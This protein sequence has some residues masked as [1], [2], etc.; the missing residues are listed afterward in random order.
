[1]ARK[2]LYLIDG[3]AQIYRAYYAPF[4]PLTSPSGEPTRATF[5]FCQMLLNLLRGRRPDY[6]A[7]VMDVSDETVFRVE[8]DP[9]Y[10]AHREPPPEDMSPQI[11]RIVQIIEALGIP[12]LRMQGFEADDIMATLCRRHAGRDADVFLVSKDK[13]LEQLLGDGVRM[14][15]PGKD[16]VIDAAAMQA[17]KGY[18]PAK[19][20]DAQMLIGDSVDNVRGLTG[21]GP[22]KAAELL[23]KYGDVAGIIAH[24]DELSPKLRENVQ[25]FARRAE[26]VRLLVTLKDD[27]PIE[28]ALDKADVARLRGEAALPLF[29]ELGFHRLTEQLKAQFGGAVAAAD[30]PARADGKPAAVEAASGNKADRTERPARVAAAVSEGVDDEAAGTLFARELT[31]A[32]SEADERVTSGAYQ[33][34]DSEAALRE[35]SKQLHGMRGF[36]FDTETTSLTPADAELCGI[37]ISW[38]AG[39]ATYVAVRGV[40][41]TVDEAIVRDVLGPIFADERIAKCGQN[42]KYD[43]GVL[44]T[45]GIEVRGV[46]FDTMIASFVLDSS[47]RSHGIDALAL[48]LLGIRKI[49]TSE[50]IGRGK[51]Q[52]RFDQLDTRRVCAYACED[53]DVAWRLKELFEPQIA[54]RGMEKLFYELEMPLVEVLAT[55]EHH[56][57][58]L[59][60]DLLARISNEMAQRLEQLTEQIHAAAGCAF[61][62]DSTKQLAEVLFDRLN[63]PV[64]KRTKTGRSTDAAVLG[65]LASLTTHP[66]PKLVLEYRELTKLKGTYVDTLPEM[67]SPRTGRVHCS[68]H[69]TG[70]VTGRLSSS[71]PNLQNIP[72]RTEAGAQIRRAFVPRARRAEDEAAERASA[73]R[74]RGAAA[75]KRDAADAEWAIMSADY[76]QIELRVLAHFCGDENLCRA[77]REDRDIH[78]FVASQIFSVP[79]EKVGKEQRGRAKT[80]NFGIIYGQTA[81]GLARQTGMSQGEARQFIEA[82]FRQYP[83]IQ[84][85]LD[86]CIEQARK[87]GFVETMLGRRRRIDDIH[88]RNQGARQAAERLA[89]NTVVQGTAAD[90]IKRA[91]INIHRRIRDE[92]RPLRM[93]IQVH[94]E[95][96][97]ELPKPALAEEARMVREEMSGAIPLS[98]PVKV[99]VAA[100]KNW[101]DGEEIA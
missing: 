28:F 10:K 5:V 51:D 93:L 29:V 65:D 1:M 46:R 96:V 80:V 33:L 91:M 75:A 57:V 73:P 76:S 79:I 14:Y 92:G 52:L 101:L 13:D 54:S 56:G 87:H 21:V 18:P 100:G 66:V 36:A 74:A 64:Q 81:F 50:L 53:A 42:L 78:A 22:K 94:D 89:V 47:R 40:G 2:T 61:N 55:M 63:L 25:E 3:H 16:E 68:F 71:D 77:F 41:R 82:Y 98:V 99:D 48:D 7:M 11:E 72:I 44:M 90:I 9:E 43:I 6:L 26:Q 86:R 27:V 45:A 24:A 60:T 85:F 17:A 15:D 31:A 34:V 19:A 30:A 37:S 58:A 69:Q 38:E 59:D 95:L 8:I 67:V 39:K 23:A 35:L 4:R 97:F 49:A 70:A 83:G 84:A 62:I 88:S 32:P 12:I 20:I